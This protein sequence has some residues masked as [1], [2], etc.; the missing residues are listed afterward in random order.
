MG[1]HIPKES[2]YPL[3]ASTSNILNINIICLIAFLTGATKKYIPINP[4]ITPNLIHVDFFTFF[5]QS[6]TF[7][8]RHDYLPRNSLEII[9]F[10]ILCYFT[11]S[12]SLF[13]DQP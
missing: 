3:M 4:N 10:T 12:K 2:I 8:Q 9:I 11:T 1:A 5:K 7:L 6:T 13:P